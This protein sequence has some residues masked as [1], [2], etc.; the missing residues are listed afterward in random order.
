MTTPCVAVWPLCLFCVVQDMSWLLDSAVAANMNMIRCDRHATDHLRGGFNCIYSTPS[1]AVSPPWIDL[2]AIW[3]LRVQGV[4]RRPLPARRVLRHGRP[5]GAHGEPPPTTARLA[6][7]HAPHMMRG[8]LQ[9][10]SLFLDMAPLAD[11]L[12]LSVPPAVPVPLAP[13]S[14]LAGDDVCMVSHGR[15]GRLHTSP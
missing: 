4:G 11:S 12:N 8:R 6:G 3:V 13:H 1:P 14:G 15:Q 10:A 9:S 7:S 5:E 2:G